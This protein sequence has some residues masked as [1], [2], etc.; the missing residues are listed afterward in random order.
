MTR[1]GSGTGQGFRQGRRLERLDASLN[2]PLEKRG[3]LPSP[4]VCSICGA[5]HEN[6]HWHWAE[7]DSPV[8]AHMARCPACER[9]AQGVPARVI[10]IHG[11]LP[12][13]L[14]DEMLQLMHDR[15][16]QANREY[17]LQRI[18]WIHDEPGHLE[19]ATTD[20]HLATR[21]CEALRDAWGGSLEQQIAED[22]LVVRIQW[23]NPGAESAG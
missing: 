18:M 5:V 10:H 20:V 23:T 7:L 14:H 6:G 15:E 19:V 4:S 12:V 17:P 11:A 21:L 3:K 22:E 8:D 1:Q 13:V 9:T 16:V 2:D